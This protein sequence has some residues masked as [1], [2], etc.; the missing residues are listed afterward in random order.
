MI[1][2]NEAWRKNPTGEWQDFTVYVVWS[3]R[4]ITTKR[5]FDAKILHYAS[6]TEGASDFSEEQYCGKSQRI[7]KRRGHK[8]R[9]SFGELW[10][11]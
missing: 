10:D 9:C 4:K 1:A 5:I 6:I 11:E 3:G 8:S 2:W 7:N